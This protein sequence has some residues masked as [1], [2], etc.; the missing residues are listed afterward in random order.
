MEININ[1]LEI[2]YKIT[3]PDDAAQTAVVLQGWGTDLTIYDSVASAVNDACRVVQFDLPGFGASQEPPE[4]WNVD[5]Y[6]DFFCDFMDALGIKSA[7]LIGHSYGGRMIIKMAARASRG[8]LPFEISKIVLVDS[9]GVMP[10]RTAA[11]NFKVKRYKAMRNFLTSRP[12]HSLF[13]EVIDYWMSKQGSDDY[14]AA[15][16]MMK[17]CLVMAVNEDLQ[18]IMPLVDKETLLVW[19]DLDT[20]TPI[21]DAHKMEEKMPNAALVVLEGTGH[22]SFLYKPVEFRNILRAFLKI[23]G[24]K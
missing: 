23:G 17:K 22:Y 10:K 4:A 19:G 2:N 21:S 3:G 11:Q 9:A 24:A 15:S 18:D 12:V 1:G 16:P 14:R 7:A 5:A 8:E 13:P 20:D 6:C